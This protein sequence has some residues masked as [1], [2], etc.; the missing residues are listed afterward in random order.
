MAEKWSS[1]PITELPVNH[2]ATFC[3]GGERETLIGVAKI[4]LMVGSQWSTSMVSV[5]QFE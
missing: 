4:S 1:D 2:V 3:L 5:V